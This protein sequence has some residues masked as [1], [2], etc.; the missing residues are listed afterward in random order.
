M[1]KL[2]LAEKPSLGKKIA[3]ALGVSKRNSN[4]HFEDDRYVV[5][6]LVGH[7]IEAKYPK[8]EWSVDN[9]PLKDL[10]K[11]DMQASKG[12]TELVSKIK[13]EVLRGDIDEIVNAGDADTEGSL[14]VYELYEYYNI[15]NSGKKFTRMWI[16]AED[17][18]TIKKAFD[19]RY[20]QDEDMKFVNAGKS[21]A[22]ADVKLGFNFSRLYTLKN[23]TYGESFNIGRVMTPTMQIVREREIEIQNF[24]PEDY[25]NVKGNFTDST[26][27]FKG[28]LFT[29]NEEGKQTTALSK[30]KFEDY[31]ARIKDGEKYKIT[32]KN[33]KQNSKKPDFLP[34]LNDILKSMSKLHKMNSKK[35]TSIM[36][37]LYEAQFCTY[38]RSEVKFLPTS[39]EAEILEVF[40]CYEDICKDNIGDK[41]INFSVQNKRVFDDTKVGSHFAIIPMVKT[42][43]QIS[44]LDA[45]HRKVLDYII[46][47]FLMAFMGDYKY[48]S[49]VIVLKKDDISFKITGKMEKD[50]GYKSFECASNRTSSEDVIVPSLEEG[51]EVKL[52]SIEVKK[53]KTKPP[54]VITELTL[55]EIMENV[56][57]LYKKQK[58]EDVDDGDDTELEFD[59]AFSLGTPATRGGII[60]KLLKLKYLNKSGQKFIVS[61][62]GCR[63]LDTAKGALNIETTA[64]FEEDMSNIIS[65]KEKSE[66]FD[67][68]MDEYVNS[69][70]S[71]EVS[72]I[73]NAMAAKAEQA[74]TKYDCPLCG[75][76]IK[77]TD[78]AYRCSASGSFDKKAKTFSGCQFAIIKYVKPLDYTISESDL[79]TLLEKKPVEVS[80][81]SLIFDDNSKFFVKID[82]PKTGSS[83][84]L[85][86]SD[87]IENEKVFRCSKAGTWDPKSKKFSGCQFGIIKYI[88]PLDYTLSTDDL[89]T[90]L[91]KTPIEVNGKKLV[92][93][94][95]SQFFVKVEL[96]KVDLQCPLC[97]ADVND[98]GKGYR[99]SKAGTWDAS[100]KK[101]SG[102]SFNVMKHIKPIK[103]DMNLEAL[104]KIISGEIIDVDG[105]KVS[106]DK[107]NPFFI[108]LDFGNGGS[109]SVKMDV[110][111]PSCDGDMLD[112]PKVF[113]CVNTGKWDPKKKK[114]D[115]KCKI[116][117]FK[118][119]RKLG[120]DLTADDLGIL[121]SGESVS[122]GNST[123]KLDL[124]SK[125]LLV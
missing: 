99:C 123:I 24:V 69:I 68:K 100:K 124:N 75:E 9:L 102:C 40:S 65:E 59:G 36:Q 33:I 60:E 49:T 44:K 29:I 42:E 106:F 3:G 46:S 18:K 26:Q 121:L 11:P 107:Q 118:N 86:E 28:D 119:N 10:D 92:F 94:P 103:W 120:R 66:D 30:E 114:M 13:K 14:L 81:K 53:N 48:E 54:S 111:C 93:D 90:L 113:R 20:S 67:K 89:A 64:T 41:S 91:T 57:K 27:E 22:L 34:N 15:L 109:S 77:Q 76:K 62:I 38:P 110:K 39:M 105:K 45:D 98:T 83:C 1:K 101:F 97:E 35:A 87:I 88:R 112:T 125:Y 2:I 25:W 82:L 80:G 32:E 115:G 31:K 16:L 104:T 72:E 78:K 61:D 58:L 71:S 63:L 37:D 8:T 74:K 4:G 73:R 47:K 23:P 6:S 43:S 117:I 84:P 52:L 55:L 95:E 56:H 12:K 85:C 116:S 108:K 122:E 51:Q 17:N 5:A 70:I 19:E 7:V 96:P 21:R 79:G 50:K